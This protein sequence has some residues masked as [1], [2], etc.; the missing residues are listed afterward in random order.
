MKKNNTNSSGI[1]EEERWKK[2]SEVISFENKIVADI[3]C[4]KGFF[5]SKIKLC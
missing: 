5:S 3:G 4:W 2:L 1:I